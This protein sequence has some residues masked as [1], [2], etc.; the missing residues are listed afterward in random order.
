MAYITNKARI[1][2]FDASPLTYRLMDFIN[3]NPHTPIQTTS[4]KPIAFKNV[5]PEGVA[6]S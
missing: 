6:V 2:E 4:I 5:F 3:A 1:N